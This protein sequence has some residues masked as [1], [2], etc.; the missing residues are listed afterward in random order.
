MMK[1][2]YGQP[3]ITPSAAGW[4]CLCPEAMGYGSTP[5]DAYR[6]WRANR[7]IGQAVRSK[8]DQ[9]GVFHG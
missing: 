9:S 5:A 3:H 8:V 1:G 2:R 6:L 4:L 7:M